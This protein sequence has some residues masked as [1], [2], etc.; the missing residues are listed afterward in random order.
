VTSTHNTKLDVNGDIGVKDNIYIG[1]TIDFGNGCF[2]QKE[3]GDVGIGTTL[4]TQSL[5]FNSNNSIR[6]K[7]EKISF[8]LD[9]YYDV[10]AL[11]TITDLG[12]GIR[13]STPL[14]SLDLTPSPDWYVSRFT[15]GITLLKLDLVEG[16]YIKRYYWGFQSYGDS[17]YFFIHLNNKRNDLLGSISN[18]W[19]F[20]SPSRAGNIGLGKAFPSE[21]LD[22]N[23][24]I[25]H[26]G[27]I[28]TSSDSRIKYD[29]SDLDD[30]E[31][32]NKLMLIEPKKYKYKDKSKGNAEVYGF[33]AQQVKDIM[34]DFAVK[35]NKEYI[36]DI[37][38]VATI[39]SN[40][41]TSTSNLE[42]SSNY[43]IIINNCENNVTVDEILDDNSYKISGYDN[44]SNIS[45]DIFIQGKLV[46]DFHLLNKTAIFTMNVGATQELYKII[47]I[48]K[49][50]IINLINR[51]EILESK[52]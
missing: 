17:M 38:N 50:I 45:Q 13:T 27:S 42:L 33:V 10:R 2:F 8:R 28:L 15:N 43:K 24:N 31:M 23:G 32:L 48:Q 5:K 25:H 46:D 4:R 26:N 44:N 1:N 35:L 7:G 30:N 20:G 34:G 49:D 12:L 37:N 6:L 51:I 21:K 39:N 52:L 11:M 47:N 41:I 36:Y 29:I 16:L 18:I 14:Y 22:V 3:T 40:I 19:I 9:T